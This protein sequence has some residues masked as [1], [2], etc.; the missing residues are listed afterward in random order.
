MHINIIF[1]SHNIRMRLVLSFLKKKLSKVKQLS[2]RIKNQKVKQLSLHLNPD[3][4]SKSLLNLMEWICGK[5]LRFVFRLLI[6][7]RMCLLEKRLPGPWD[8]QCWIPGLRNSERQKKMD[9]AGVGTV[10]GGGVGGY[11]SESV[12]NGLEAGERELVSVQNSSAL[13][14]ERRPN[15]SQSSTGAVVGPEPPARKLH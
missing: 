9:R 7:K 5:D 6:S 13:H 1:S 3:L 8:K 12:Q 11:R 14:C 4:T 2:Q 10:A 15:I